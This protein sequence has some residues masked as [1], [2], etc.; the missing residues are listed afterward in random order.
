M[1]DGLF[2]WSWIVLLVVVSSVRKI[3][4]RRAGKRSSLKGVPVAE[5]SMMVLWGLAA[6][7]VPFFYI[8]S[9]WLD[10]ADYPFAWPQA[11]GVLGILVFLVLMMFDLVGFR[12]DCP[13]VKSQSSLKGIVIVDLKRGID[14][15]PDIVC[16]R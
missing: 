15:Q 12:I 14:Q 8:F 16:A 10:F 4:E 7:V 9:S 2:N 3:H 6:G 5:A 11:L 1:P 13:V